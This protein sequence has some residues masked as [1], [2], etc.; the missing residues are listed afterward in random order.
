M[1]NV[2]EVFNEWRKNHAIL[3]KVFLLFALYISLC[4]GDVLSMEP[5]TCH[6]SNWIYV[7]SNPSGEGFYID[8]DTAW[9]DGYRSGANVKCVQNNGN[10]TV[11]TLNFEDFTER[12]V[13]YKV[14]ACW[15]YDSSGKQIH[16]DNQL[17]EKYMYNGT[18]GYTICRKVMEICGR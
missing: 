7:V 6:A 2:F 1:Q 15:V 3:G 18:G 8:A 16:Y 17:E 4:I 5:S 14:L 13:F 12:G 9:S 11:E 10:T